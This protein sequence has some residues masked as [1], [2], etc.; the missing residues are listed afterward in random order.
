M[1]SKL[2]ELRSLLRGLGSVVIAYSGGVDS[3]LLASLA[4][5]VL[6]DRALAVTASSPIH[7]ESE[8]AL[9]ASAA[10]QLG[11]RHITI[12]SKEM[13]DPSFLRNDPLR[14]Y[15][16]KRNLFTQL[17]RIAEN[18]GVLS[19]LD[20]TNYDDLR[21]DRP[22]AKAAAELGVTSPLSQI[23]LTK[24]EIRSVSR[25]RGLPNWD[26]PSFSCLATRLPT[27]T[28]ITVELLARVDKAEQALAELGLSQFRLRHHGP[29]ARIE[30]GNGD[31]ALLVDDTVRLRA[32]ERLHALGYTYVTVDLAGYRPGG[33]PS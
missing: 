16:C 30:V 4:T 33:R 29:I 26:K 21:D 24:A 23:G 15:H 2:A 17:K 5:E 12:E 13:A 8:T 27:G 25:E 10:Q 6:G 32:V 31:M 18:E 9:A 28:P 20:G 3:T 1:E 11:I 22:G 19:V 7:P 14:C